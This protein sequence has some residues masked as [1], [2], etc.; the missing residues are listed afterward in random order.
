MSIHI[1]NSAALKTA[2]NSVIGVN[3][4][5]ASAAFLLRVN[6]ATPM[7]SAGYAGS[8]FIQR[9][10]T[11]GFIVRSSSV[12]ET[13]QTMVLD[14]AWRAS[15]NS[16]LAYKPTIYPGIVYSV[17]MTYDK[18][19]PSDQAV[20]VNGVKYQMAPTQS[21]PL[22]ATATAL[23]VGLVSNG[24]VARDFTVGNL[25]FWN[26][27]IVQPSEVLA[28]MSGEGDPTTI[29]TS[30]SW[31]DWWTLDGAVGVTPVD[32]DDA[33]KGRITN[34][35]P[36]TPSVGVV[37]GSAVAYDSP[38]VFSSQADV[39]TPVV[40]S[41]GKT[42][43]VLTRSPSGDELMV[44]GVG[45]T[46]PTIKINGGSPITLVRPFTTTH[47]GVLYYLPAGS[48]VAP[49]D[50]VSFSA[51]EGYIETSLGIT[52]AVTDLACI[53]RTNAPIYGDQPRNLFAGLNY[54]YPA[55]SYWS[56]YAGA[57]NW[58]WRALLDE[59][60][61]APG[62]F[63]ADGTVKVNKLGVWLADTTSDTG[64]DYLGFPMPMGKW[65]LS[66]IPRDAGRATDVSLTS[67]TPEAC[68]ELQVYRN[69]GSAA[70]DRVIKVFNFENTT[71]AKTLTAAVDAATTTIP[72]DDMTYMSGAALSGKPVL[73]LKI[74]DEYM[75]VRTVDNGAKTAGVIRG[76]MG[77]TAASHTSGTACAA[78][79]YVQNPGLKMNITGPSGVPNYSDL[80]VYCPYDWT[81]PEP[82]GPVTNLDTS[83]AAQAR[84]SSFV[85]DSMVNS[86]VN[87]FM[88]SSGAFTQVAEPEYMR[89]ETDAYWGMTS[90]FF[91]DFRV[92]D[93]KPFTPAT[94]PYFYVHFANFPGAETY[95]ATLGAAVTTAPASETIETITI[96]D[97]ATA[98]V[99][100]G[101]RLFIGSEQMRVVAVNGTSVTVA[102]GTMGTTTA[103]HATGP[104]TVGWRV[105]ITTVDQYQYP[106]YVAVEMTTDQPHGLRSGMWAGD[107][108][109]LDM[110][111]GAR[112]NVTLTSS[113]ASGATT[114]TI[115]AD[116]GDW[117]YIRTGLYIKFGSDVMRIAT[118]DSSTG[119]VTVE[120]GPGSA[121]SSG[122]A[123]TTLCAGVF[124]KSTDGLTYAW[125]PKQ[126]VGNF[127]YVLGAN[128]LLSLRYVNMGG[129]TSAVE[130]NQTWEQTARPVNGVDTSQIHFRLPVSL[131]PYDF[132]ATVSA[133]SPGSHHWVNVPILA[134]D[135]MVRDM[136]VQ[137][138]DNLPNGAK[139]KVVVELANETWNTAFPFLNVLM[140]Y[141]MLAGFGGSN[142][143]DWPVVRTRDVTQIFRDVFAETN[144]DA[145]VLLSLPSQTGAIDR[146]LLR[147]EVHG[148]NVDVAST[149][150]YH[151]PS[152][153]PDSIAAFN[154]ADDDQ[155]VDTWI[156]DAE[157]NTS[158]GAIFKLKADA[159][160]LAAYRA[161]T[162]QNVK[163]IT[164][165]GGVDTLLPKPATGFNDTNVYAS[166]V[167]RNLDL[168]YN[169]V[170]YHAHKDL[171]SICQTRGVDGF[172]FFD[173]C[174]WPNKNSIGLIAPGV[175]YNMW[176]VTNYHGQPAGR[177]DGSDGKADNR[178]NLA[179]P[180]LPN[181]K[182]PLLN[183]A[184]SK[185]SVRLQAILDWNYER[186]NPE[187][188]EHDPLP[189]GVYV[190]IVRR[191]GRRPP[192]FFRIP[193]EHSV[194][195][196]PALPP[197]V[198]GRR[199]IV[200][201]NIIS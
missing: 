148:V 124:C 158:S 98:P 195:P 84:V 113:L 138:R 11:Q 35:F 34:D 91:R 156:F 10:S 81:P 118:A 105:P 63:R 65:V 191:R 200:F 78:A 152:S 170:W 74:D 147:A 40:A 16:G 68:K 174:Q 172:C 175:I 161:R 22:V 180:G 189:K 23:E 117:Q 15:N 76:A 69:D 5:R 142:P 149:A 97:A 52:S 116:A 1:I 188:E 129:K 151:A 67:N 4:A 89:R 39:L 165:E 127:F 196:P 87:R 164:Y 6:A 125:S 80:V 119:T 88:D 96:S 37:A 137:I 32:G 194:V 173:H 171:L 162:G 30:A 72:L 159:A 71:Y 201:R 104:I 28:I 139:H 45:P 184:G 25:M 66:Y 12:D 36:F 183:Y 169:P 168:S 177:G 44:T 133:L 107:P 47:S 145:T 198:N 106:N 57:C 14:L 51:P 190:P 86:Q 48:E 136:A 120:G 94:S 9:S 95:G 126:P 59:V 2:V 181:S 54:V 62:T 43:R 46:A 33:L 121:H 18:D 143:Y 21:V 111:P 77:S 61:E 42:I 122:E 197:I 144:H 99:I 167:A 192:S 41:S 17:V 100:Q 178:Q 90:K 60:K 64:F 20:Y 186:A 115:S 131:Y 146:Q 185:V 38:L 109:Y 110:N 134:S 3:Q 154:A 27:Y 31:R 55:M 53:N 8:S 153:T 73:W 135:D 49:G 166:G 24:T 123:G 83:L 29:G 93:L 157:C 58:A 187:P 141:S 26:D 19:N 70:G 130:G 103:T 112:F 176:G 199:V 163:W 108:D 101:S 150:P 132:T 160:K 102:R 85:R 50:T 114:F 75:E 92:T 13:N 182:P 82:A 179:Q 193:K 155:C 140:R 79:Y 128:R 7:T 56:M